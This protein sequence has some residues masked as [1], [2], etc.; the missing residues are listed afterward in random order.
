[1]IFRFIPE[2][3]SRVAALLAGE[4]EIA[5]ELPALQGIQAYVPPLIVV[6]LGAALIVSG[7]ARTRAR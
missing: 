5:A 4:V 2:N 6:A 1:V 7:R 3:A